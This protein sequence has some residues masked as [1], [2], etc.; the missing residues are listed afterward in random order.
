MR[1]FRLY[2]AAVTAFAVVPIVALSG[3]GSSSS[4]DVSGSDGLTSVTIGI[5]GP[6]A[7][8]YLPTFASDQGIL[9]KYGIKASFETLSATTIPATLAAGKVDYLATAGPQPELVALKGAPI[10]ELA[11]WSEK[12]DFQ[13]VAGPGITSVADLRGKRLG[14]TTTGSTTTI[15]LEKALRQAGLTDSDVKIVPLGSPSAQVS[16][17]SSGQIDAFVAGPP[18]S[19]QSAKSVAGASV[20]VNYAQDY[21]WPF[22]EMAA[23]MPYASA[24]P[25]VTTALIHALS[26]AEVKWKS[27]PTAAEATIKN[28]LDVTD[29]E[30]KEAYEAS[31]STMTG[32]LAPTSQGEVTLLQSISGLAPEA[33]S[34]NPASLID[35]SYV[36]RA[37]VK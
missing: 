10:K 11:V 24:H 33:A 27:S 31:L 37:G 17:F 19:T 6:V 16:A 13:L 4:A 14:I 36:T 9:A 22:A 8:L 3:C 34:A 15:F 26:D 28:A 12:P 23:Y 25:D 21:S 5:G 30:A 35:G 7:E 2:H 20:L 29:E 18:T 1:K 32:S